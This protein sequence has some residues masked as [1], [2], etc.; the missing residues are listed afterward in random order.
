MLH[1]NGRR[2]R[3]TSND[4]QQRRERT[5]WPFLVLSWLMWPELIGPRRPAAFNTISTDCNW[6][7]VK[8]IRWLIDSWNEHVLAAW[9]QTTSNDAVFVDL[10][11]WGKETT[12]AAAPPPPPPPPTTTTTRINRR[13][14]YTRL[15]ARMAAKTEWDDHFPRFTLQML[16][17]IHL[18]WCI[19]KA[20]ARSP[21]ANQLPVSK[22]RWDQTESRHKLTWQV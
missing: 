11:D 7:R 5:Q 8:I 19:S 12:A 16:K 3:V 17:C 1:C 18:I 20:T 2:F 22:P 13:F 21:L 15:I 9:R 6:S 10:S 4:A 14:Y